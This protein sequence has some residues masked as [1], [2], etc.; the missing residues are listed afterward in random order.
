MKHRL[1]HIFRLILLAATLMVTV[2]S[3]MAQTNIVNAGQQSTLGIE[4]IPGATYIWDLYVDNTTLNFA[5]VPGNCPSADAYFVG[6]SDTPSVEVMWITPGI[7]YFRVKVMAS[8]GCQNLK[9]GMMQVIG[10]LPTAAF[11]PQ[12]AICLGQTA[13]LTINLTGIPPW[14]LTYTDGTTPITLTGILTSPRL[15]PV[16]PAGT[17]SYWITM[18]NDSRGVPNNAQVGPSV[19]TVNPTP[20]VVF[21]PCFDLITSIEAKPFKL[22]GGLPLNGTYS[23]AGVNSASGIFNPAAAPT[24]QVPITYSYTNMFGCS[25]TATDTI[26]N[27]P[28]PAFTCGSNWLDVRDNNRGY[29]TIQIGAQC[30]LAENLDYGRRIQSS[31]PQTNNCVDEK[32]CYNNDPANCTSTGALYQWDELMK[33]DD[34]PA[35]QG[36]CPPGWHVPTNPEWMELLTF[37][38]GAAFAG[39]PLQDLT[40]SGFHALPGGVIYQNN[41]WSH[42]NLAALFW[43]STTVSPLRAISHGMNNKDISV[44]YY[45]SLR[46]NAFPVRCL[47]DQ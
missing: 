23:G 35:A 18:V 2:A 26:T 14:S 5:T 29:A 34:A 1:Q 10:D 22:R 27:N 6:G 41:A 33:Y 4:P 15:V 38:N 8:G 37:Y 25:G 17:T 3:A 21:I 20:N 42:K 11:V 46:G 47:K 28:A 32:Y 19:I 24:G 16:S 45:E 7:Y 43:T 39:K 12:P 36:I 40:T 44:S 30:W 13:N 9:I 31:Q